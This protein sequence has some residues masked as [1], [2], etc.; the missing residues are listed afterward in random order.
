MKDYAVKI[1]KLS[2]IALVLYIMFL[3]WVLFFKLGRVEYTRACASG[4]S[5]M[6][7]K[8][9]FLFDIIIE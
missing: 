1:K 2:T 8:E 3:V 7:L 9:R 4:L 6:T 5:S